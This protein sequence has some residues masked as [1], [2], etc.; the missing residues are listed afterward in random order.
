VQAEAEVEEVDEID[1]AEPEWIVAS[2]PVPSSPVEDELPWLAPAPE[3]AIEIE[4]EIEAE[5]EKD[6][7][8]QKLLENSAR[9]ARC[10]NE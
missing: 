1:D 2:A 3:R 6:T 8:T 4:V 5:I 7:C 10:K 9:E